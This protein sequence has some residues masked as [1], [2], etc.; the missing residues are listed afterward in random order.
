MCMPHF[1]PP[2]SWRFSGPL[3]AVRSPDHSDAFLSE[4]S[5]RYDHVV[6][7][8]SGTGSTIGRLPPPFIFRGR[9]PN[10]RSSGTSNVILSGADC[11]NDVMTD[12]NRGQLVILTPRTSGRPPGGVQR[13]KRLRIQSATRPNGLSRTR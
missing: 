4:G 7:R 5:I 13:L 6:P 10:L 11:R 12:A 9:L 3:S 8:P 2:P 1:R